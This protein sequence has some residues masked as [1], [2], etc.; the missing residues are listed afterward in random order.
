LE[1][2]VFENSALWNP[3][4]GIK[5]KLTAGQLKETVGQIWFSDH[6]G[7]NRGDKLP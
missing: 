1:N 7:K 5:G 3:I 6:A 2:L 4:M